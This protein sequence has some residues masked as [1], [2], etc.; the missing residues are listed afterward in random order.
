MIRKS[1]N[2]FVT[3][4][5]SDVTFSNFI[6]PNVENSISMRPVTLSLHQ[7][8]CLMNICRTQIRRHIRNTISEWHKIKIRSQV[9]NNVPESGSQESPQAVRQLQSGRRRNFHRHF[10][11]HMVEG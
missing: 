5:I 6:L 1:Q 2:L 10:A 11:R 8:D 4:D 9:S 7:V 3:N